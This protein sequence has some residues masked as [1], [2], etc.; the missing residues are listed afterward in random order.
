M[1]NQVRHDGGGV[2][3]PA[4]PK[5]ERH[6]ELDSGSRSH[7]AKVSD[8]CSVI[9]TSKPLRQSVALQLDTG[10]EPAEPNAV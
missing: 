6:P 3:T 10:P 7:A 5:T 8:E 1:L 4:N 9:G 2:A